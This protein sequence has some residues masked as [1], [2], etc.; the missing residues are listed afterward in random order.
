[1]AYRP[2][3]VG[4]GEWQLETLYRPRP[5]DTAADTGAGV[6]HRRGCWLEVTVWRLDVR[7]ERGGWRRAQ[8][9]SAQTF[10]AIM[11]RSLRLRAGCRDHGGFRRHD[12]RNLARSGKHNATGTG[13]DRLRYEG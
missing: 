9:S 10:R 1:M 12:P 5:A 11:W 2:G 13:S 8:G 6:S 7:T 4:G 3:A